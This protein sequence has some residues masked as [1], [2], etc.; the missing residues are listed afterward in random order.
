MRPSLSKVNKASTRL[1]TTCIDEE[2]EDEEDDGGS[3]NESIFAAILFV[4]LSLSMFSV[5][6]KIYF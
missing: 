2:E 4:F 5:K 6:F 3:D 1:S